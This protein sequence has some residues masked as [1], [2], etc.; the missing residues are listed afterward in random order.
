MQKNRESN[1]SLPGKT[2]SDRFA[3]VAE[4]QQCH[5][6]VSLLHCIFALNLKPYSCKVR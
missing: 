3:S 6:L 1:Y 4:G 2:N 5:I